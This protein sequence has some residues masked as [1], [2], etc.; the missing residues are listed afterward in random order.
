[1][2]ERIRWSFAVDI[3]DKTP[4][5][6]IDAITTHWL[7]HHGKPEMMTWDGERAL[8]SLEALQ[9]ASRCKFQLV[10]RAQHS[11]A[12]VV[13]RHNGILR[14][15]LHKCQ[16]QLAI[17]GHEIKFSNAL[18]DGVFS[19]TLPRPVWQSTPAL[20]TTWA[21]SRYFTS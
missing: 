5:S 10:P 9:W 1:M 17:E 7:Q 21:R 13:G 20:T 6:I 18:A 3:A 15:A 19:K 14:N 16:T 8:V 11:K 12:W 4:E 2:D